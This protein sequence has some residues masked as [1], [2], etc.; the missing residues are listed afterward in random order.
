M[1]T[2]AALAAQPADRLA[3]LG[4]STQPNRSR[5]ANAAAWDNRSSWD[6]WRKHR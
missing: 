5:A 2:L 6:N 3:K 4:A 1:T